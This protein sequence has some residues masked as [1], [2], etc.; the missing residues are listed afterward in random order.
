MDLI[1]CFLCFVVKDDYDDG[2]FDLFEELIMKTSSEKEKDKEKAMESIESERRDI[3]NISNL[4]ALDVLKSSKEWNHFE[5]EI[6][7]IGMQIE[8]EIFEELIVDLLGF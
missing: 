4:I 1:A 2:E 3:S 8:A 5:H 7:E 6:K